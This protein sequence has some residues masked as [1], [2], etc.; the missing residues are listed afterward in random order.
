MV[1]STYG[2]KNILREIY[3][4]KAY[5]YSEMMKEYRES[6]NLAPPIPEEIWKIHDRFN[7]MKT[8]SKQLR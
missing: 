6:A 2:L 5:F 7:V 8:N 1:P 3:S 4:K